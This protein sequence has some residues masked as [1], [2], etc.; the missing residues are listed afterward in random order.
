MSERVWTINEYKLWVCEIGVRY[1]V[2][3]DGNKERKRQNRI[4]ELIYK[5]CEKF[6]YD[7]TI[8]VKYSIYLF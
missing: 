8:A 2:V 7:C 4:L 5:I 3:D 6:I 1:Y